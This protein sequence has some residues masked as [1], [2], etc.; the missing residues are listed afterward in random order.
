LTERTIVEELEHRLALERVVLG[1]STAFINL[2]TDQI[3]AGVERALAE[4]GAFCDVD[5]AYVFRLTET[6]MSNTHEWCAAG[7]E[8]QLAH[9]QELPLSA[10]PWWVERIRR[11]EVT[12]IP[13]V[14]DLPDEAAAERATLLEQDIVSIVVV[15]MV[16]AGKAIG[17]IG[18]DSI[19]HG[20]RWADE[21]I[22]LL[23]IAG[24]I[25]ANALERK[26]AE[27][28]RGA[29]EEQLIQARSLD[30]VAR[31]AGGVAHDFNNL[32]TVIISHGYL[33]K[34]ACVDAELGGHIDVLLQS[35]QQAAEL[36]RQLMIVG[37]RDVLQ[38]EVLDL[39]AIVLSLESLLISSLG[40]S[41][42]L[43]LRLD[44]D[45]CWVKLGKAHLKQVIVNLAVN[46]RDALSHGGHVLIETGHVPAAAA[47]ARSWVYLRVRD[48]GPGMSEEVR[49]R[50]FEPFFSTKGIKGTGLGLSTLHAI[51]QHAGGSVRI[52]SA[53]GTGTTIEV[54]LP[55]VAAPEPVVAP[56]TES[57]APSAGGQE[58]ILL[59]EDS[60]PLRVLLERI[61]VEH[62]Y[63]VVST[64]HPAGAL[65]IASQPGA[66]FDLLLTD[67]ILPAMSGRALAERLRAR[68]PALA[69]AY[70]SGHDDQV[71]VRQGVVDEGV[72]LLSK[73]FRDTELLA[74]VRAV[75][76]QRDALA[77][78]SEGGPP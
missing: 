25:V 75:L 26:R 47:E 4:I 37:R 14:A 29:L 76:S 30:N 51:V 57:V 49:R 9:L 18:F 45:P 28:E 31:L 23:R 48:D 55:A 68:F 70:I 46:A 15:P 53:P 24:E 10:F 27:A 21:D 1:V 56:A 54:C 33:L 34:R 17:F 42:E 73:P 52:E 40:E 78:T 59:V 16:L 74:F 3:D 7:V 19:R 32:L 22:T 2:R 62:G 11:R 65:T 13:S 8:P 64:G 12:H 58:R 77:T 63:R 61:L 50:A 6:S 20:K 44:A 43:T 41:V 69:I 39:N 38:S 71:L 72:S 67:V 5:R 35:A 66:A 60:D 36:T